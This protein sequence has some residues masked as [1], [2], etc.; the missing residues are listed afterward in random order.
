MMKKVL[1]VCVENSGR[2]Q[3]A[4][5]F[6]RAYGIDA[7]SAGTVP[8]ATLNPTVVEA[9]QERGINISSSKPKL[10]TYQMIESADYV[11]TMGCRVVD[12]CPK[13]LIVKMD[14]KLIDW[15]IDDPKGQR[16]EEVRKIR[17]QIESKVIELLKTE[18]GQQSSMKDSHFAGLTIGRARQ[19][20]LP[21]ILA[22]LDKCELPKEGLS[23]HLPTTLVA[24]N[25]ERIVGSSALE[26]YQDCALLRSVAVEPSF[27]GRGL[28][29][30]LTREALEL[31][32]RHH[33][34]NV[35]LLT[36]TAAMFFSKVGFKPV[37]R[38]NVPQDIRRSIE[39]TTLCPDTAQ[40]MAIILQ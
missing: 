18:E 22:L 25:G 24:R 34:T 21:T 1:F 17:A 36:E 3:M 9:M 39:F 10:L 16:I 7:A 28:G 35:Y 38:A 14:K 29:L 23:P 19:E 4:E 40:V 8:A 15:H 37:A 6:A 11:V 32:K 5:A 27:R 31:A 26:L 13:P 33:L 12:V 20:E 30:R 2:S